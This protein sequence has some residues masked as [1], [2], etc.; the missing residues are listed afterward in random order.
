MSEIII[1][2]CEKYV[3][4]RF[5]LILV[6]AKRAK[7]ISIGQAKP[8]VKIYR[9]K[10]TIIALREIQNGHNIKFIDNKNSKLD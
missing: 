6:A 4:N 2:N 7:S 5:D 1:E 8:L 3:Q 10:P 9:D